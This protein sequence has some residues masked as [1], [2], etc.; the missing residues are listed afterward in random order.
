[1]EIT[2]RLMLGLVANSLMAI[3]SMSLIILPSLWVMDILLGILQRHNTIYV[4]PPIQIKAILI[5]LVIISVFWMSISTIRSQ[6]KKLSNKEL[7]TELTIELKN[8]QKIA[9]AVG[10][11][12]T[13]RLYLTKNFI[14]KETWGNVDWVNC[15]DIAWAYLATR[16]NLVFVKLH[17]NNGDCIETQVHSLEEAKEAL[18]TIVLVAPNAYFGYSEE[19]EERYKKYIRNR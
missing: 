5:F 6:M 18:D 8:K 15:K 2:T 3:L 1:M 14:V 16:R 7:L 4:L 12:T 9:F 17:S 10:G 19:L 13:T 11:F